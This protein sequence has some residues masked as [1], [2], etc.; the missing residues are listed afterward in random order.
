V[1]APAQFEGQDA[2]S[3]TPGITEPKLFIAS[4]EDTAAMLSLEELLEAASE[5]KESETYSGD[6]HGTNLLLSEHAAVFRAR[7]LQFLREHVL[8][9]RGGP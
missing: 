4:E 3:A 7:I 5:P 2:L 6:A 1:S 8:R 9:D